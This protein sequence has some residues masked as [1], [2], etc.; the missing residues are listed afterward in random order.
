MQPSKEQE[1][2]ENQRWQNAKTY[3][4]KAPHEYFVQEWNPALFDFFL[5]LIEKYGKDEIFQLFQHRKKYRCFYFGEYRYWQDDNVLNRTRTDNL[6]WQD[7]VSMPKIQVIGA[8]TKK[9][10]LV[11]RREIVRL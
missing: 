10:E 3:E 4:K 6:V 11:M 2:I 8:K 5:K 9:N 1:E 7:G